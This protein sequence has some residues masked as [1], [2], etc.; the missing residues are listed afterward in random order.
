MQ[1]ESRGQSD[2]A[3]GSTTDNID[4][5]N[6]DEDETSESQNH[7][8][9]QDGTNSDLH[10]GSASEALDSNP[11]PADESGDQDQELS[12]HSSPQGTRKSARA[13]SKPAWMTSGDYVC[14]TQNPDWK[15]R[16]EYLKE[17]VSTNSLQGVD[18]SSVSQAFLQLVTWKPD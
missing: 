9:E 15:L 18:N 13:K 16:A 7:G 17:L 12:T 5:Q 8:P 14:L 1:N 4:V 6:R 2:S 11:D 10:P 3:P